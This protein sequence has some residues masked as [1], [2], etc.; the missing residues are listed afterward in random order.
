MFAVTKEDKMYREM[1][2][3][4]VDEKALEWAQR[5]GMD[6]QHLMTYYSCAMREVETKLR[7]LDAEFSLMHDRNPIN[8]IKTRLKSIPSIMEKLQRKGLNI[9][10]S[11]IEQ[12]LN[13]I[14]GVR[15]ICSFTQDVYKL[16]DALLAQD[17][18]TLVAYKDYIKNPK[19]NGYRSLHLIV[20][21]PIF[22]EKEK[23]KM[24]VEIQLRTIAMDCW[25]SLEHQLRYKKGKH[26]PEMTEQ[27]LLTCAKL[28]MELDERMDGLLLKF[29]IH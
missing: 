18:I 16:A 14:A 15:V 3:S 23:R 11:S 6:V 19:P 7:V 28:S 8:S 12:E 25:A 20:E 1:L 5:R 2:M 29:N 27:E 22:L 4:N 13:D 9:S 10:V 21:V 24:K 26:L 17:D